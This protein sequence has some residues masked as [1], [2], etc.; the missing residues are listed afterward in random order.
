MDSCVC[1][2]RAP[3]NTFSCLFILTFTNSS[4]LVFVILPPFS[5]SPLL[6]TEF[7]PSLI[8][9]LVQQPWPRAPKPHP[10][11]DRGD[12]RQPFSLLLCAQESTAF[13]RKSTLFHQLQ[14][15]NLHDL[16]LFFIKCQMILL[17]SKYD[18]LHL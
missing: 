18:T 5:L 16:L 3:H 2:V 10:S 13:P 12:S 9:G 17:S 8:P 1:N 6:L 14:F 4:S 11:A 15:K 7:L